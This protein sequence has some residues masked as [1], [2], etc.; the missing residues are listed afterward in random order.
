MVMFGNRRIKNPILQL[1]FGG[2]GLLIAGIVI[3]LVVG[4][5][6]P[7]VT[8]VVA[9]VLVMV[10]LVLLIITALFVV[11]GSIGAALGIV[12]LPFA[13]FFRSSGNLFNKSESKKGEEVIIE[14]HDKDGKLK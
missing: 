7:L 8:A 2:F 1:L 9:F 13:I 14:L 10:M 5:V 12:L 11:F 3:L 4:I 6:L